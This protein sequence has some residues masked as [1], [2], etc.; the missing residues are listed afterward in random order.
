LFTHV[1]VCLQV[2]K[3]EDQLR[4]E[5]LLEKPLVSQ[6]KFEEGFDNYTRD[7]K[8][9]KILMAT[10]RRIDQFDCTFLACKMIR[11]HIDDN[12][13]HQLGKA[14]DG[15]DYLQQLYL[16]D[17]FI[18]DGG[19]GD[20]A[21][22]LEKNNWALKILNLSGN[23]IS[24]DGAC[25]FAEMLKRNK[26][27]IDLNLGFKE[28]K[29]PFRDRN[30]LYPRISAPG[31]SM[32]AFALQDNY[33][34][35]SLNL[36]GMKIWD[37]GAA[38][39]AMTLKT[40]HTLKHLNL[41]NNDIM[42]PGGLALAKALEANRGLQH[43]NL[44]GNKL[45]DKVGFK[46]AAAL[47]GAVTLEGS[48]HGLGGP[49]TCVLETLDLFDND[50]SMLGIRSLRDSLQ[51]N[52]KLRV[53]SV[54]G[55]RGVGDI[56]LKN[57]TKLDNLVATNIVRYKEDKAIKNL[58][59]WHKRLFEKG[60]SHLDYEHFLEIQFGVIKDEVSGQ[61]FEVDHGK[62]EHRNRGA[63]IAASM[64]VV[65]IQPENPMHSL[66][67]KLSDSKSLAIAP[68]RKPHIVIDIWDED[69]IDGVSYESRLHDAWGVYTAKS[70]AETGL[71]EV[72]VKA[73][74]N[75]D[76][77]FYDSMTRL[78]QLRVPV[79]GKNIQHG[80]ISI[81][82]LKYLKEEMTNA[83]KGHSNED[84]YLRQKAAGLAWKDH[85]HAKVDLPPDKYVEEQYQEWFPHK[86]PHGIDAHYHE[87]QLKLDFV[88]NALGGGAMV[89]Y[90][91]LSEEDKRQNEVDALMQKM[92]KQGK[93]E[94]D[95]HVALRMLGAGKQMTAD[96]RVAGNAARRET[97]RERTR[98]F[99]RAHTGNPATMFKAKVAAEMAT[100][101]REEALA[102]KNEF[103]ERQKKQLKQMDRRGGVSSGFR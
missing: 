10:V 8:Q 101:Q 50:L 96:E 61:L 11:Y 41:A 52:D 69:P 93:S 47:K 36:S 49:G 35:T 16:N 78:L 82:R 58:V 70:K 81:C 99:S 40:R 43:F 54:Y 26:N 45:G 74:Y 39:F 68:T 53:V 30:L 1:C 24:D 60:E 97:T 15:N 25:A 29:R 18:T 7:P 91:G 64:G 44:S 38:A 98:K 85:V 73:Y 84:W 72:N 23:F 95:R 37:A 33:S 88:F 79:P 19:A 92:A 86:Y 80:T 42:E 22:A 89:H 34:L 75:G 57:D 21:Q 76:N 59:I 20:L 3:F 46:F 55:N 102:K 87:K 90:S 94:K 63:D 28:K 56:G 4:H 32:I 67:M 13:A 17:N 12:W 5:Y 6:R 27:L 77:P 14:L 9:L 51:M 62:L 71:G 83:R 31:G 103:A 66:Q 48:H 2:C 100:K 65:S